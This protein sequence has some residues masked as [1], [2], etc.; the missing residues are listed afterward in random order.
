[1]SKSIIITKTNNQQRKKNERR[2]N[3]YNYL[4]REI[5]IVANKNFRRQSN[6]S[7]PKR[8]DFYDK[9]KKILDLLFQ[10]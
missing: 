4:R 8:V 5:D 6:S 9:R 7:K 3:G 2:A 1:M 10:N